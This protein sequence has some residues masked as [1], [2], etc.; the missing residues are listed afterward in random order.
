MNY[1]LCRSKITTW[2]D[3]RRRGPA[4]S[5][6]D[7]SNPEELGPLPEG[8]ERRRHSDGRY[9]FIDHVLTI[10]INEFLVKYFQNTRQTTWEDPRIKNLIGQTPAV[11]YSRDYKKK[12]EY[13]RSKI[14]KLAITQPGQRFDIKVAFF[15]RLLLI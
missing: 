1:Y 10:I 13:F 3:P 4:P 7:Y 2:D 5:R 15:L 9:F 11:P 14:R 12:Y 8:W 6:K